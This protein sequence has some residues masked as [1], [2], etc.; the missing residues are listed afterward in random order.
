MSQLNGSIFIKLPE[1]LLSY[2]KEEPMVVSWNMINH[3]LELSGLADAQTLLDY[4]A[5][6][7]KEEGFITE[8]TEVN[9]Q[10]TLIFPVASAWKDIIQ[11][12][13]EKGK[14][15]EIYGAIDDDYGTEYY[16]LSAT[17]EKHHTY[18]DLE[19]DDEAD[20]QG[21]LKEFL[22]K[23]PDDVKKLFPEYF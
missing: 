2:F 14:G 5:S 8:G 7:L 20:P 9:G 13:I 11:S 6:F 19:G 4:D 3:I 15:I 22:N 18:I 1:E 16:A 12:L 10:Y 23:V 17:G 21:A